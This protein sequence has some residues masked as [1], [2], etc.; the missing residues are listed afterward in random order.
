MTITLCGF[1]LSNYYNKAK[2]VLL[3]KGVPFDEEY[4]DFK[5]LQGETARAASPIG[6][7]RS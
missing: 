6:K 5:A 2:M 1:S 3:E 4:Q 7:V